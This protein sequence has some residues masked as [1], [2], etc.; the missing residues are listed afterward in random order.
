M[1]KLFYWLSPQQR[2]RQLPPP[3]HR[4]HQWIG[5]WPLCGPGSSPPASASCTTP[6]HR[7]ARR[8][9]WDQPPQRPE[10]G[11]N[12]QL[13]ERQPREQ[14]GNIIDHWR[15]TRSINHGIQ[16]WR[17]SS[18]R[19]RSFHSIPL[20]F[21]TTPIHTNASA[22]EDAACHLHRKLRWLHWV[23]RISKVE[24]IGWRGKCQ[25]PLRRGR[26]RLSFFSAC[27]FVL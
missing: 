4:H 22:R 6:L 2:H 12:N 3:P 5:H 24:G 16:F 27:C 25:C 18:N 9:H 21:H 23:R 10:D 19:R 11:M 17:T 8:R 26:V 15:H 14:D 13:L 7:A 20:P 1:C